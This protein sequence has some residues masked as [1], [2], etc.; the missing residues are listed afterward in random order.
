[1]KTFIYETV[2]QH[3]EVYNHALADH[4]DPQLVDPPIATA[5]LCASQ[6]FE[7]DLRRPAE[8]G[9][10][11][12]EVGTILLKPKGCMSIFKAR[13]FS[14]DRLQNYLQLRRTKF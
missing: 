7:E 5:R 13:S 1:M 11:S 10:I 12:W 8:L 9:S 6:A 4:R 3:A 2:R 14:I